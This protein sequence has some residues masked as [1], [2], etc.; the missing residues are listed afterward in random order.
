MGFNRSPQ[1]SRSV[2][3]KYRRQVGLTYNQSRIHTQSSASEQHTT[4]QKEHSEGGK[5][6]VGI[7]INKQTANTFSKI[8]ECYTMTAVTTRIKNVL[9]SRKA[10]NA[11]GESLLVVFGFQACLE[12]LWPLRRRG[13]ES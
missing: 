13:R 5:K 9:T 8:T 4:L 3:H 7:K 6:T 1:L 10:K 2:F 11:C 12:I